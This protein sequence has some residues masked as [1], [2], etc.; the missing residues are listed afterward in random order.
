MKGQ[1][2]IKLSEISTFFQMVRLGL[3][4]GLS[5]APLDISASFIKFTPTLTH[6]YTFVIS[7]CCTNIHNLLKQNGDVWPSLKVTEAWS[8]G[9]NGQGITIAVVDNGIQADHPDLVKRFVCVDVQKSFTEFT[10]NS[11]E[12]V[13]IQYIEC[14]RSILRT[15]L[16]ALTTEIFRLL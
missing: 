10:I 11:N 6:A 1:S 12:V 15:F 3:I 2:L 4:W 16:I 5:K 14:F 8:Q 9:Y 13:V 7:S